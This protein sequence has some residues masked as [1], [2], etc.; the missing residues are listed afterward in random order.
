MVLLLI[1]TPG[2]IRA[3]T[4][5]DLETGFVMTGYNDVRIPGDQGTF[6]SLNRDLDAYNKP[7]YRLRFSYIINQRH[8][9]S[10]LFAPLTVKS[11]GSFE[12][13]ITFAGELFPPNA[14]VEAV[15]R[16]NSY[17]LT[18][19]YDFVRKPKVNF[20]VGFTAKIR[21]AKISLESGDLFGEKVN[22]GFV[23]IINFRL[24]YK[25]YDKLNLLFE[26]DALAAP[27]GRAEDVFAGATY[28]ISERFKIKAGYRLL[29]GGADNDEVYTFSMF[30]YAAIGL[31][32]S[33]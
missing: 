5:F 20:G 21:D 24:L 33:F 31:M 18:Y 16:F 15:Y 13:N 22:V 23:P 27:Q 28:M 29:E 19:R 14:D 7:Y 32:V 26:G 4:S 12:K 25:P 30:H 2:L 11:D 8:V 1:F 6:F 3:Q 17:R 9:I 10:A